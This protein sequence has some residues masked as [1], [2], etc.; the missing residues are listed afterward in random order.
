MAHNPDL[1]MHVDRIAEICNSLSGKVDRVVQLELEKG[2]SAR[3]GK[4]A[5]KA[6]NGHAGVGGIDVEDGTS[7]CSS[8]EELN[9]VGKYA[10]PYVDKYC[11]DIHNK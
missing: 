11:I 2:H 3:V 8:E 9:T 5:L 10:I 4:K 7:S 1:L 6:I